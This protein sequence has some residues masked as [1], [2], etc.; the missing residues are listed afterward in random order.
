MGFVSIH[1]FGKALNWHKYF[2]SKF[3]AVMTWEVYQTHVKKRFE[4]V[5]EDLVV[6]LKN[7][8]QTTTVQ[9]Y[10]DSFEDLLNK[11]DLNEP[12][13]ISLFI[14]GLKEEIAYSLHVMNKLRRKMVMRILKEEEEEVVSQ[15]L[16][17]AMTGMPSYQT[18]R[19]KGHVM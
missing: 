19:V 2:M 3:G 4:Y 13:A 5:F 18:M 8:K 16:L 7:L 17:N 6:E 10:Q 11:V 1:L 15:I 9:V 14:G 12:Y